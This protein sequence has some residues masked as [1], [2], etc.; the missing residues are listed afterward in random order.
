MV[1]VDEKTM[2]NGQVVTMIYDKN[3][4]K[5]YQIYITYD[6]IR[7]FYAEDTNR[8]DAYAIYNNVP[9]L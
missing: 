7:I 9:L 8:A 4:K 2:K 5:P 3:F 1:I 6:G